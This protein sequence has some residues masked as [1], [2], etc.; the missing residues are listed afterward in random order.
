MQVPLIGNSYPES[1]REWDPG[2]RAAEE[3][4]KDD[5]ERTTYNP[6]QLAKEVIQYAAY[7]K[8]I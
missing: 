2:K 6:S 4:G 5:V 7:K 3:L 8:C 1:Y